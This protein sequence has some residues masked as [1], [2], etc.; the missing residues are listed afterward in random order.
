ML[1]GKHQIFWWGWFADYPDAENFLFLLYGPERARRSTRARTPPTTRTPSSTSSSASCRRWTTAREKQAVID[2]MVDH[3]A[4]A[5]RPGPSATSRMRPAAFQH[6]VYNGKPGILIRDM[7][8]YYRVDA[9]AAR[10]PSRPSGTG[11]C[12]WP[13][14]LLL[15]A[16]AA[17]A[18]VARRA[19]AARASA[20]P[21]RG[22]APAAGRRRPDADAELPRPPRRS[23]AL[24]VLLGVNLLHLLPVLHRQHARRHGAA[25][26]RR[27]ARDA[28]ADR[29]VEG[30]ARLRQAAVLERRGR[31]RRARSPTRS[32]GSARSRCSRSTSAAP[33]P[34]APVDIGHEIA[35]AHGRQPAAGGAA[36]RA[37]GD[38]QRRVRA[39]AG[40]LPA[41]AR[42]T[43]GASCCAC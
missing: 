43:S 19:A 18:G 38:R 40:V 37:A 4:A 7:A 10:A 31:G 12:C 16:G 13:L 14:A 11:R 35:H 8:R 33:T 21:A 25:E 29:Q 6:W 1:K 2:E 3:R 42:S 22:A 32:S 26:H 5:T 28:G 20:P 9:R 34:R 15:A 17:G 30:R 27:Q 39:A 41:L 23:T 24:L 36:L